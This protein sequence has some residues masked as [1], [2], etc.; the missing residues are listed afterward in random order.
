MKRPILFVWLSMGVRGESGEETHTHNMRQQVLHRPSF[1][2]HPLNRKTLIL[3]Q[4]FYLVYFH[5]QCIFVLA[6]P[7]PVYQQPCFPS[8]YS[9]NHWNVWCSQ[10]ILFWDM[11]LFVSHFSSVFK[12]RRMSII[13][14]LLDPWDSKIFPVPFKFRRINLFL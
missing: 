2:S 11:I 1:S 4:F 14:V 10:Q 7:D 13:Q 12:A 9:L 6:S 8:P 5:A 3:H